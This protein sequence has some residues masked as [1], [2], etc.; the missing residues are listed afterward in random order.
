MVTDGAAQTGDAAPP[1]GAPSFPA[2]V[3]PAEVPPTYILAPGD[4]IVVFVR[5]EEDL[6]Q[7]VTIRPDGRVSIP[8]VEDMQAAGR[9]PS[10]LARAIEEQ[11]SAYLRDPIVSVSVV[12]A[13]GAFEQQIRVIGIAA[14][15][16]FAGASPLFSR[17]P[18]PPLAVAWVEGITLLDVMNRIGGLSPYAAGNAAYVLRRTY[19]GG[20]HRVPVRLDDLVEE[21][22]VSA[23]M[24]M[25]PGDILV[26]PEGAL[27]GEWNTTRGL[28]AF[29]TFTDNVNLDPGDLKESAVIFSLTPNISTRGSSRRLAGGVDATLRL[30]FR[31]ILGDNERGTD[32]GLTPNLS[33]LGTGQAVVIPDV[34]FAEAAASISQ[35]S[36]TIGDATSA[37]EFNTAGT[38][39]TGSFRFSPFV[40]VRLG[41]YA[42]AQLRYTLTSTIQGEEDSNI[43]DTA[44]SGNLSSTRH[45]INLSVFSGDK[46]STF[47]AWTFSTFASLENRSD[48]DVDQEDITEAGLQLDWAYPVAPRVVALATIGYQYRDAGSGETQLNDPVFAVGARWNPNPRLEVTATVG[49]RDAR[50]NVAFNGIYRLSPRTQMF[51]NYSEGL[52]STA[53]LAADNVGFLAINPI[54]GNFVDDRTE[55]A[56]TQTFPGS[57]STD[58]SFNRRLTTGFSTVQQRN[59]FNTSFSA[60]SQEDDVSGITETTFSL[61]AGWNRQITTR[62]STSVSASYT[63]DDLAD[64]QEDRILTRLSLDYTLFRTVSLT[65]SYSLQKRWSD[66]PDRRFLENVATI[67][68]SGSF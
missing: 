38:A 52:G 28:G 68:V 13:G 1:S 4:G 29:F 66:D 22:D 58:T 31:Q 27:A 45:L 67:G 61:S 26:V 41:Q 14:T 65:A 25:Q 33:L 7:S 24:R 20:T 30:N 36:Q 32:E 35:Q 8:L 23:N 50:F 59:T 11:L 37:S 46:T 40:P 6:T 9:T 53:Q 19:D 56:F 43:F 21:S 62:A 48:E 47:G 44:T 15:P 42:S 34:L 51:A 17:Q 60:F 10:E 63:K 55:S 12:S 2:S 49:Q 16:A 57:I 5:G 3:F 18:S 39:P 54:T 64:S